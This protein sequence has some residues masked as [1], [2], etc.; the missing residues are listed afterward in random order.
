MKPPVPTKREAFSI[1][2]V[3]SCNTLLHMLLVCVRSYL[4]SVLRYKFLIFDTYHPD[5]LYLRKPKGFRKQK[6]LGNT[7]L[8]KFFPPFIVQFLNSSI[9]PIHPFSPTLYLMLITSV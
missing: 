1:I 9:N 2:R 7:G 8:L 3:K 5:T 4:I 6:Y